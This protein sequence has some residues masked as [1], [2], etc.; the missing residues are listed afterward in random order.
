MTEFALQ[1]AEGLSGAIAAGPE[2]DPW[3]SEDVGPWIGHMAPHG[4]EGAYVGWRVP[5]KLGTRA[6]VNGPRGDL[7]FTVG[8]R[9][10][11]IAP[12]GSIGEPACVPGG[13]GTPVTALAAS[14]RGQLWYSTGATVGVFSPPP[15]GV[16]IAARAGRLAGRVVSVRLS[17]QGGVGGE[18]CAGVVRLTRS[19]P[20]AAKGE[21]VAVRG[22]ELPAATS[23]RLKISLGPRAAKIL[24]GQGRLPVRVTVTIAGE[25]AASRGIVLRLRQG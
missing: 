18:S 8:G 24:Y 22:Y 4:D 25:P 12:D 19:V 7:W 1:K 10:G 13:C 16:G 3:F 20:G 14:P 5:G 2:G 23:R 9:I 11:S 17:C 21:V 6:I 15:L